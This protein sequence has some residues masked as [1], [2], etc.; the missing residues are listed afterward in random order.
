LR[1]KRKGGSCHWK[2]IGLTVEIPTPGPSVEAAGPRERPER[3]LDRTGSARPLVGNAKLSPFV[4]IVCR[5]TR[6]ACLL[7]ILHATTSPG[8]FRREVE[9]FED[10]SAC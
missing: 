3:I 10:S 4:G 1:R 5:D 2:L 8:T 9:L 6:G 7:D